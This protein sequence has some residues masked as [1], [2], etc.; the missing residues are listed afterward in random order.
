MAVYPPGVRLEVPPRP[1]EFSIVLQVMDADFEAVSDKIGAQI[2]GKT[3]R[4]S[5]D[6]LGV[7]GDGKGFH[8]VRI[9]VDASKSPPAI[10]YRRDLSAA[11]WPLPLEIRMMLRSGAAA[12]GTPLTAGNAVTG[13]FR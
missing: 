1:V 4:F 9:V 5:A 6:V 8:R 3:Y 10:I 11:G 7:S 12:N 13:T 2:T